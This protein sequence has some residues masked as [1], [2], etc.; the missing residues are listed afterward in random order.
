ML[1]SKIA[2]SHYAGIVHVQIE[3]HGEIAFAAYD[4]FHEDC[5]F[6]YPAVPLALLEEL[7]ERRVLYSYRIGQLA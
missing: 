1:A 4:L 2:F 6:V 5:V 7:V 3:S